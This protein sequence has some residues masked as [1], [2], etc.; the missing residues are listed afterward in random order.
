MNE[1]ARLADQLQRAQEGDAWHGPSLRE[2]LTGVTA[3]QA[4]AR[5]VP[6]A[7][8]IW[9][10]VHHVA[11]WEDAVRRR[12]AG[13]RVSLTGEGD[14]PPVHEPTEAAWVETRDRLAAGGRRLRETIAAFPPARLEELR[15]DSG[16]TYY[17][18]IQGVI[19]HDLYHAGQVGLLRKALAAVPAAR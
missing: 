12:L 4:A 8:S 9:E 16:Q 3:A 15:S 18:L 1:S 2:L 7:H 11:A 14:W 13:E 6:E 10:I 19:Q 17:L 5:P